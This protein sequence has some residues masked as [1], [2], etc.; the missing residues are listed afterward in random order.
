MVEKLSD[1]TKMDQ[2]CEKCGG[3]CCTYFC[4]EID[5]PE[6]YEEFEDIR[7][8]V[9]HDGVSVHIDDGDWYISIENRCKALD[10]YG[11]CSIY[12]N[13]PLICRTYSPQDGCDYTGSGDYEYDEEFSSPDEVERYAREVL[14]DEQFEQDREKH[15]RKIERRQQRKDRDR[16]KRKGKSTAR[17]S[18][19]KGRRKG[20]AKRGKKPS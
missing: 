3:Q 1:D 4:F 7:W 14:G 15:R 8:Y 5:E 11:R 20:G 19:G 17:S 13:R 6:D 2:T 12:E 18:K 9:L 16:A 10:P